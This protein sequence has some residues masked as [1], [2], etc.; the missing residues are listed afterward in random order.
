VYDWV[1]EHRIKIRLSQER[2]AGVVGWSNDKIGRIER[3]KQ[4]LSSEEVIKLGRALRMSD[5][6][7]SSIVLHNV[8]LPY[9]N[10]NDF[11]ST[12]REEIRFALETHVAGICLK[13]TT[14]GIRILIA[15]RLTT[16]E[17]YPGKWEC[18]GGQVMPGENYEEAIRRQM[19]EELGIEVNI[20]TTIG[21]YEIMTPQLLQRKIPGIKFLCEMVNHL[22]TMEI[23]FDQNEFSESKW[24]K[25]DEV[26]TIDFIPGI[27]KDIATALRIYKSYLNK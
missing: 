24:I 20:I 27:K 3:G 2:L 1:K 26:E 21:T 25:E 8:G 17:L 18:G 14:Q 15:K 16:R 9:V 13:R 7:L 19:R 5:K 10:I 4:K 11:M 22:N 6:E 23:K 12:V